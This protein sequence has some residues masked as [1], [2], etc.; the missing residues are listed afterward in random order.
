MN[1]SD[2]FKEKENCCGCELCSQVCPM[3][4]IS[5]AE[6]EEGFLYPKIKEP[7]K[8]VNCSLCI[9]SCP[10]KSPGRKPAKVIT[11]QGGYSKD[12]NEV[13][14]SSSGGFATAIGRAFIKTGGVVYG[15]RY[16]PDYHKVLYERASDFETLEH[17][18]TS[19]YVQAKKNDI[20]KKVKSDIKNNRRVLFVGLPCEVSA[21]Y[22]YVGQK[23][24]LLYT[25][26]LICHGPTSPK[27][28]LD[29]CNYLESN[30]KSELS[31]FSV[32]YKKKGWKPYY[33][34]ANFK[35]N[36]KYQHLFENS[37]YGIAFQYLKRPSCS[38][39][40]YKYGDMEFGLVSDLTIG[41]FHAVGVDNPLFNK[42]GV[43][44]ASVQTE[45]GFY[46]LQK[47]EE[48]C[49]MEEIPA[50]IIA[51]CNLAFHKPISMK[52]RRSLFVNDYLNYSLRKACNNP[53]IQ[54][55]TNKKIIVKFIRK[56]L[57]KFKKL[58]F[59]HK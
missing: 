50:N 43:S 51:S 48:T 59:M 4:L 18:R 44:Q 32:R 14:Q 24:D 19:K 25:I 21:L 52:S 22:H 41:D 40:R 6:D 9:K 35:N 55:E 56:T 45:K 3:G 27:V 58:L 57:S 42:W 23:N 11:S 54:Y 5:M 20:Y 37:L 28:H 10:M 53:Y 38:F 12:L 1:T 2:L 34:N 17:F 49:K 31:S 8:C 30:C 7:E 46:L 33:I 26:T 39:C 15:V 47:I 29:Y 16:S 13:R 36:V